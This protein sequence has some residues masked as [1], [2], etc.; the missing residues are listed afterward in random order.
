MCDNLYFQQILEDC[1][2]DLTYWYRHISKGAWPF[3]T[4]DNGWAVSDCTAEGLQVV[5]D[6]NVER[7]NVYFSSGNFN[8]NVAL[9]KCSCLFFSILG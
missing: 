1:P 3:S 9:I 7:K 2:G 8:I 4:A 6:Q 5:E